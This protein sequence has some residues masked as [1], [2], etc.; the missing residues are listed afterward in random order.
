MTNDDMEL[1]REYALGQSEKAFETL[2][3]RHINLV[4]STAI[5]Q[6]GDENLAE[7]I[8]QAVFI[9][10]ARK[11]A[12]LGA[13][14]ILPGWLY[15]TACYAAKDALRT[16]RRRQHHE[17][18]AYM[19][20]TLDAPQTDSTWEQLSPLLDDAM[21]HL[22]QGDRDALVLRFFEGKSL[23]EVGAT[24]GTSEEAAKKRVSRALEKL[25]KF[26]AKRGVSS[27]T[28]IIG[29]KLSA[30]SIQAA[31][32]ALAKSVAA[33]AI[34]KGSAASV[35]IL[36]IIKGTLKAMNQLRIKYALVGGTVSLLVGGIVTV[37][38]SQVSNDTRIT[39]QDIAKESQ[40]AYAALTSYSDEGKVVSTG[41]GENAETTFTIRM[42]RPNLF[43]IEW[44][45]TGGF[46]TGKGT[47]W[48]D[49]TGNF[50][51]EGAANQMENAKRH[52]AQNM[53]MALAMATGIS[54]SAASDIPGTFFTQSW[55]DQLNLF[56]RTYSKAHRERESD[57]KIGDTDCF[58]ISNGNGPI[59]LPD[60]GTSGKVTTRL[61]IGKEDHFIHQVETTSE[62]ASANLKISDDSIKTILQ[63]QGK[64]PTADNIAALRTE[65]DK[66]M[67]S[68]GKKFV[69]TQTHENIVVNKKFSPA[70]FGQ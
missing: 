46:Y 29:E 1:L 58:V 11:S 33:A 21:T 64:E 59:K 23:Q 8:T 45:Q 39:V 57:E 36:T 35:S 19:Q 41:G 49:G 6:V 50:L 43:R 63:R 7:E 2:V 10:L 20:S 61:W 65:L 52:K 17:Q 26:F 9:I 24:F 37:A 30:H 68:Q 31:P 69:S 16:Q 4:Y 13:G 42:Q 60:G 54:D 12:T 66:S 34:V 47:V 40:A 62:G 51:V 32:A 18:E 38:V 22:R 56:A 55:G 48:S 3:S 27:T 25:R 14:T 67:S 53:Q 15:R 28:A 5:R 70:D 44:T